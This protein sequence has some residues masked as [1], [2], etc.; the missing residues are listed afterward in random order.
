MFC[1]KVVNRRFRPVSSNF[2]SSGLADDKY[3]FAEGTFFEFLCQKDVFFVQPFVQF[4]DEHVHVLQLCKKFELKDI[5]KQK[6]IECLDR[7]VLIVV[8]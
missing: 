3:Y 5:F 6:L 1:K 2:S 8:D 7:T 4:P